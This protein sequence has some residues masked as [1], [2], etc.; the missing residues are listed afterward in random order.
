MARALR[1]AGLWLAAMAAAAS[2]AAEPLDARGIALNCEI[3]H[4]S[5][6]SAIPTLA[7]QPAERL[8]RLLL[9]FKYL[10]GQATL[11]PRIA[12]GYSDAELAALADYFSERK[13]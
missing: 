1:M 4:Q 7:G 6:D 8:R 3:C 11:M 10:V 9:D 12:K 5:G 2:A 13:D